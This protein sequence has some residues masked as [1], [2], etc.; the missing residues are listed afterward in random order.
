M[1]IEATRPRARRSRKR[2]IAA[3]VAVELLVIA[4]V[5]V[6][7]AAQLTVS[8]SAVGVYSATRC[9]S[10]TLSVHVNPTGFSFGQN[11]SAVRIT[12]FPAAC[13]GQTTQVTVSNSAGTAIASGSATCSAAACT[14]AT[15]TY[16]AP[17]ATGAHVLV[18]TWGV[19]ASWDS[20]CTVVFGIFMT[21]T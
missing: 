9:S 20:V 11:K 21:C 10:A 19:P 6:A 12:N 14:I 5:S 15:G 8:S 3:I 18:S 17:S 13:F 2:V 16:N 7:S 1:T 4:A